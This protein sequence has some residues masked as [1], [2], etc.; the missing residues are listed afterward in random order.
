MLKLFF[1]NSDVA[2]KADVIKYLI[3]TY[4][5]ENWIGINW[6]MPTALFLYPGKEREG[7]ERAVKIKIA[8]DCYQKTPKEKERW[9]RDKHPKDKTEMAT[10]KRSHYDTIEAEALVKLANNAEEFK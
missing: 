4:K 5:I 6:H 2:V 10:F 8:A 9:R 7:D 3:I 1:Y